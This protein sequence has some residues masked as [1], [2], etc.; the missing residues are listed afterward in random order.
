MNRLIS[1]FLLG[2][3][4]V[5]GVV[6]TGCNSDVFIKPL[7][8]E[9]A[10]FE[11]GPD[12]QHATIRVSGEWSVH[13][14]LYYADEGRLFFYSDDLPAHIETPFSKIT[15]SKSAAGL[16]VDM[17]YYLGTNDA[18]L[19]ITVTND[20]EYKEI[21]GVIHPTDIFDVE[22]ESV[23]YVLDRWNGYPDED[24]TKRIG[25]INFDAVEWKG[26]IELAWPVKSVPTTYK[27]ESLTFVGTGGIGSIIDDPENFFANYVLNSG[28]KVPVPSTSQVYGEWWTMAGQELPLRLTRVVAYLS[29]FPPPPAPVTIPAGTRG[30]MYLSCRYESVGFE[31]T[32]KA[33]NPA[34]KEIDK[35]DCLL[36]ILMPVELF[37]EDETIPPDTL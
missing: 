9:P 2:I 32:I 25:L 7:V 11:L 21:T 19:E 4:P 34:T 18:S 14:V 35:I 10:E 29:V 27:F 13:E 30:S 5:L 22:I 23:E 8:V 26:D 16:E 20:A 3:L 17:E 1:Y 15:V 24:C 31:C 6:I 12:N 33:R 37:N 36:R 28:V